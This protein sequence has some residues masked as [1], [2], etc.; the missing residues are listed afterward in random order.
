M[1]SLQFMATSS[2]PGQS[3]TDATGSVGSAPR[4]DRRSGAEHGARA[5]ER[6]GGMRPQ[7][8]VA[9]HFEHEHSAVR[10]ALEPEDDVAPVNAPLAGGKVIV[11]DGVVVARLN[12]NDS[13]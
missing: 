3:N 4:A 7:W 2:G 5:R 8:A 9:G 11:G 6:P 1:T 13:I 12:V 10:Q